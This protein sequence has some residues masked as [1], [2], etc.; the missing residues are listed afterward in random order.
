MEQIISDSKNIYLIPGN[1]T[2]AI[3]CT[4][5]LFYSLKEIGKN[6]NLVME[7]LPDNLKFLSPSLDF[8]SYPK[9]FVISI[10]ESVAK[11]NQVYYEKN[12]DNLKIHLSLESGNIK[13]DNISLY[14]SEAK[15][16]LVIAVGVQNYANVLAEKLDQFAF[17]MDSPILNIDNS[18]ENKKFGKINIVE[19]NPLAKLVANLAPCAKKEY[20]TCLLT[21]VVVYTDNFK[22]NITSE[23]F[24]MA[25]DFMKKEANLEEI[26]QNIYGGS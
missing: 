20:A 5:A 6:V 15:P 13:K 11:V 10:P 26:I 18:P 2:E 22:K 3:S 21:A 8:I 24:Q 12:P 17:L 16:D 25:A 19:S 1:S 7:G 4:L 14:F 23:V 9:N